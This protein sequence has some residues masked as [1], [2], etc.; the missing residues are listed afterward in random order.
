VGAND[1]LFAGVY[2]LK[3]ESE[4]AISSAVFSLNALGEPEHCL[5]RY[6]LRPLDPANFNQVAVT[7]VAGRLCN[8]SADRIQTPAAANVPSHH[9]H[10]H[11][12]ANR[13]KPLEEQDKP[14]APMADQEGKAK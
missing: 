12:T 8:S 1:R 13:L 5:S 7:R 14:R 6:F 2:E 11:F 3:L 9:N 10:L 4:Q